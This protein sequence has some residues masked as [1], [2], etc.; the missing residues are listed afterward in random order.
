MLAVS[1]EHTHVASPCN[2]NFSQHDS[3]FGRGG[4][5]EHLKSS[6]RS[7]K[8]S[9]DLNLEITQHP[10]HGFYRSKA[11]DKSGSDPRDDYTKV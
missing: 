1:T 10:F 9:Y 2:L 5:Q 6:A 3:P 11:R 4:S 8:A 7:Y